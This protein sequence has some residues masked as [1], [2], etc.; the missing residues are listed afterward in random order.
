[1]L[2]CFESC[3]C[4]SVT[5]FVLSEWCFVTTGHS[6]D[7]RTRACESSTSGLL[8]WP[9]PLLLLL[10]SLSEFA[11]FYESLRDGTGRHVFEEKAMLQG[12]EMDKMF[13]QT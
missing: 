12:S 11:E 4:Q 8:R 10:Q 3:I 7:Y 2:M 9:L 13:R 6:S 1:M 5:L